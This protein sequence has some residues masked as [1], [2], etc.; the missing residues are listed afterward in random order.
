MK[1]KILLIILV[2]L[3][4]FLWINAISVTNKF[5]TKH[6][7]V[8]NTGK[9]NNNSSNPNIIDDM[10]VIFRTDLTYDNES[11]DVIAKKINNYLTDDLKDLQ[12]T[13][14]KMKKEILDEN[15]DDLESIEK[16]EANIKGEGI[17]IKASALKSG[18]TSDIYCKKCGE[19]IPNDSIYCKN[20]GEK[21]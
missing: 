5:V 17:K 3:V 20:C 7:I 4:N 9:N 10:D 18:L 14:I 16:Q 6:H 13:S 2:I 21:Q 8:I 12:T 1:R 19:K 11:A 15:K